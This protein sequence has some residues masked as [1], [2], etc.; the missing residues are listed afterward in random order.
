MPATSVLTCPRASTR[1][2]G[3][4][5]LGG[6]A[7]AQS[8][9]IKAMSSHIPH[10]PSRVESWSFRGPAA[11]GRVREWRT[12]LWLALTLLAAGCGVTYREV[13]PTEAVE[14]AAGNLRVDVQRV[15]LTNDTF[16]SGVADGMALVVELTIANGGPVPYTLKPTALWCLM[17]IDARKP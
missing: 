17:Q 10:R 15:F 2:S 13:R 6:A 4:G 5:A 12:T 3:G 1:G 11:T 7:I 16:E 14:A 9:D 8:D